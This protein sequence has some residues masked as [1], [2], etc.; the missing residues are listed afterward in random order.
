MSE[1][2]FEERE[3]FIDPREVQQVLREG[4]DRSALSPR[5]AT[6]LAGGRS[7]DSIR[8]GEVGPAHIT[9]CA[10]PA[11]DHHGQ[12]VRNRVQLDPVAGMARA[13]EPEPSARWPSA[14][15]FAEAQ[16]ISWQTIQG[17]STDLRQ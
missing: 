1:E 12:M 2:N 3:E 7:P 9:E 13:L 17:T 6:L 5:R 8:T 10:I 16:G 11:A 14:A 15:A 4:G